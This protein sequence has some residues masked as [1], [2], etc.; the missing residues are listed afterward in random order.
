MHV[1][2][3][4]YTMVMSYMHQRCCPMYI[5][6]YTVQLNSNLTLARVSLAETWLIFKFAHEL[7]ASARTC[8]LWQTTCE[9][10]QI[11]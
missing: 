1:C 8:L 9:T 6:T 5:Y 3:Y 11:A 10:C 7:A 2:M 4:T